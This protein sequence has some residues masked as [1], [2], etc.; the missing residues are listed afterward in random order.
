[1]TVEQM[2]R[3][4]DE[5]K[6]NAFTL[7]QKARWLGDMEGQVWTELLRQS[8]GDWDGGMHGGRRL[9]LPES[10]RRL[11]EAWL[12]AMIDLANGEYTK[13]AASMSL[14][15]SHWQALAA[16]YAQRIRPA[17]RAA[18]WTRIGRWSPGAA[19]G[20]KSLPAGY[21]ILGALCRVTEA[22]GAG[23]SLSLGLDGDKEA[24]LRKVDIMPESVGVRRQLRLIWPSSGI[25]QMHIFG[26]SEHSMGTAEFYLLVQP[27][28]AH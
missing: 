3:Q 24:L 10:E 21:G 18:F 23:S 13:Y 7:G 6:P 19:T 26:A 28:E 9:L 8:G 11:Y 16:A 14:Y 25:R 2:I 15:N 17:D 5:I 1:M 22:F 4:V 20:S 12:G 27:G